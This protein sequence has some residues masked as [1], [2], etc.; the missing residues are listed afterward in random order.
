MPPEHVKINTLQALGKVEELQKMPLMCCYIKICWGGGIRLR[1]LSISKKACPTG[2]RHCALKFITAFPDVH[3]FFF[4]LTLGHPCWP[5]RRSKVRTKS[6]SLP[7]CHVTKCVKHLKTHWM[8]EKF[9]SEQSS[10]LS[11]SSF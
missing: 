5:F 2:L 11:K 1:W 10:K 3:V 4:R 6:S 8:R 7:K 9:V